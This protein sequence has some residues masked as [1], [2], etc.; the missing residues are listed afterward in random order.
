MGFLV[1]RWGRIGTRLYLALGFA[2]FLTLVSSAVGVY[3]F[4]RSGDL[5]YQVRS[6]SVPVLEASWAAARETER[7]RILGLGLLAGPESGFE[8]LQTDSVVESLERLE[9]ALSEVSGVQSLSPDASAVNGAAHDL[10]EVIDNLALNRDGLIDANAAAAG[11]RVRLGE[12]SAGAGSSKVVLLVLEQA[13]LADDEAVLD[14]LWKEFAIL[15]DGGVDPA[16]ASLAGEQ[17]VFAV[18]GLQLAL[19]ANIMDLA[20]TFNE[21]SAA[22]QDSVSILLAASSAQAS[23]TLGTCRRQF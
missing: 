6:E 16:V 15:H 5:N 1:D 20:M 10:G 17:G 9:E 18:R 11:L 22:L 2:V 23:G 7:L 14:R 13:L 8:G 3:Y 4:E 12:L 21:S 19:R